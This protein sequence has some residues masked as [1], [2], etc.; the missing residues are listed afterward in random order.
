MEGGFTLPIAWAIIDRYNWPKLSNYF[1]E[2]KVSR[3]D[4]KVGE[5][6]FCRCST[7]LTGIKFVRIAITLDRYKMLPDTMPSRYIWV[8]LPAITCN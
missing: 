2:A 1:S 5:G 3:V 8:N 4:G 7:L 6:T